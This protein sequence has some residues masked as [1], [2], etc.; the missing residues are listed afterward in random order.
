MAFATHR[1]IG[2]LGQWTAV[3]WQP[4]HL[5]G[6]VDRLWHFSGRVG[7]PRERVLPGGHFQIVVHLSGRYAIVDGARA[8]ACAA[9][10]VSGLQTRPFVIE[11]PGGDADVLGIELTPAAARRLF[12]RPL[13]EI[14][15]TDVDL[16]DLVGTPAE[17]LGERCTGASGAEDRLRAAAAWL[18]ARLACAAPARGEDA[19]IDWIAARIRGRRGD[20]SI[21]A[22]RDRA[23]LSAARL[24]GRFREQVG[25]TPKAYARLERFRH[26]AERLR[27]GESPADVAAIA[28]YCDQPHLTQEFRTFAG[29]T[30]AAYAAGLRYDTGV[31]VPEA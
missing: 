25:L 5:R 4:P 12:G 13:H 19:A 15:G 23:G 1:S 21:A 17:A 10:S 2:A 22:L 18:E 24:A 28:G 26:A 14:S 20:V 8:A 30:P 27:A 31:N 6:A 3:G 29:V 7:H 11:A 16:C 9:L